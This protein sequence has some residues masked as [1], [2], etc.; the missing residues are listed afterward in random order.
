M[1]PHPDPLPPPAQCAALVIIDMQRGLLHGPVPPYDG[2]GV[3]R[4]IQALITQA[5]RAGVKVIFVQHH[6]GPDSPL[7]EGSAPWQLVAGLEPA[8]DDWR[9]G[10]MRPSMFHGTDLDQRLRS[11]G[12]HHL[13]IAGMQTEYCVDTSCRAAADLGYQ[14]ILAADGHTTLDP[15]A[16]D[17]ARREEYAPEGS[18]LPAASIIAHHNLTLAGP[19]ATVLPCAEIRFA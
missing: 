13:I 18:A 7:A 17:D 9:I 6:A 10:K 8:P 2:A 3:V 12:I 19:F 5:R 11:A 4:R 15:F 14:V 1:P 16:L